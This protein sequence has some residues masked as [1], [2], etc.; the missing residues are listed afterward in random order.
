VRLVILPTLALVGCELLDGE[1][2]CETVE[3]SA[4]LWM[5]IGGDV[6]EFDAVAVAEPDDDDPAASAFRITGST[7]SVEDTS[8]GEVAFVG[9]EPGPASCRDPGNALTYRDIFG[10]WEADAQTG[11]TSCTIR[12]ERTASKVD[13]RLVGTF[14]GTVIDL[15]GEARAVCGAFDAP[16][17]EVR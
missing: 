6:L 2:D 13:E 10:V 11:G 7:P 4:S 12:I 1:V 16:V 5:G 14:E 8:I 17:A 15:L 9:E 3:S